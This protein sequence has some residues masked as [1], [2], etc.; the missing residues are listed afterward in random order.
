VDTRFIQ[1]LLAVVDAGS[2]AAAARL[3]NLTPAAVAQRVKALEAELNRALIVRAGQRVA[4]TQACLSI[5]PRLGDIVSQV[6]QIAADLDTSGL[7]GPIR[8]G[9]I[10]T[11]LSDRVPNVL[12]QFAKRAPTA[13][14]I[15]MPGTSK[16][17]YAMLLAGEIDAAFVVQP[18]F[19]MPKSVS[20]V[21]IEAQPMVMIV[22]SEDQ[23]SLRAIIAD[24]RALIYD[25]TSWGGKIAASWI[26]A[27][28]PRD[29]ILCELDALEAIAIAVGH[30]VGFSIVPDWHG[31]TALASVRRIPLPELSETRH[32]VLL[33]RGLTQESLQLL[34]A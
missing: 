13:K 19:N 28:I 23:R 27:R 7:G 16:D 12:R 14:I 1:T 3:Q 30:G 34:C 29:R 24:E 21:P 22:S 5:L 31:L 4:P 9:A 18:P 33:H 2:F 8:I 15:V 25:A 6:R 10:S 11:A 32:T 26:A 20:C 17:L